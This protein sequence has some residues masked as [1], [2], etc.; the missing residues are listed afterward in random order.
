MTNWILSF[1]GFEDR[2][3]GAQRAKEWSTLRKEY[4]TQNPACAV[5]D[6]KGLLVGIQVHHRTPVHIDKTK[7][8]LWENLISLCRIHHLWIGHLGSYFSFNKDVEEDARVWK[9]KISHRP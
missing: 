5:C 4:V 8:L 6:K 9:S 1:F 7:E 3:F 2:T